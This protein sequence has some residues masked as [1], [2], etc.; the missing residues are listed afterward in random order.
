MIEI[1]ILIFIGLI[2]IQLSYNKNKMT[3][4]IIPGLFAGI[5]EGIPALVGLVKQFTK[6]KPIADE[7]LNNKTREELFNIVKQAQTDNETPWFV[8]I[9]KTATTLATIYFV[10]FVSQKF[11]I[12]REDII[13]LF[14]LLK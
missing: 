9:L 3:K 4:K 7:E 10:L 11:G 12:T 13:N 2:T 1:I 14:G 5:V 6:K 8:F